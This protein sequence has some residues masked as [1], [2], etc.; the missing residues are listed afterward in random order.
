M[1]LFAS[2]QKANA[3]R[4]ATEEVC[5][6]TFGSFGRSKELDFL[7]TFV[8]RQKSCVWMQGVAALLSLVKLSFKEERKLWSSFLLGYGRLAKGR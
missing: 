3:G 6:A 5:R 4:P 2:R 8:S 7:L 1:L